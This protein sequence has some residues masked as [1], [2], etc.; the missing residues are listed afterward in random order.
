V[1]PEIVTSWERSA[2]QVPA[3][4]SGAP[5]ADPDDVREAW[6]RTPLRVAVSRL[7]SELRSVAAG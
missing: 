7:E 1:R 3:G 5:L 6:E 2:G 4:V